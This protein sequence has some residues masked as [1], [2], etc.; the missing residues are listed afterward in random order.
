MLKLPISQ[1]RKRMDA[2]SAADELE[3]TVRGHEV[4][5]VIDQK[6]SDDVVGS[7]ASWLR[8]AGAIAI[9]LKYRA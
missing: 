7:V 4:Q 1:L 5:L 2:A 6:V 8:D 9:A 3:K